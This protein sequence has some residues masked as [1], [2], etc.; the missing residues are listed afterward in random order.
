MSDA[1]AAA[2]LTVSDNAVGRWIRGEADPGFEVTIWASRKWGVSLDEH[3]SGRALEVA[4]ADQVVADQL[5]EIRQRLGRVEGWQQEFAAHIGKELGG[6]NGA[7]LSYAA[8]Q[9]RL[10]E[11]QATVERLL[12]QKEA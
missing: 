1:F 5:A 9:S 7:G 12:R 8:M 4:L 3:V 10:A 11:L 6:S 2:G